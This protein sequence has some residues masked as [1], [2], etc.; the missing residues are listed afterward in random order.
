MNVEAEPRTLRK[1]PLFSV[2]GL[3]VFAILDG[4]RRPDLLDRL[5]AQDE[6]WACLFSGPLA[7]EVA[8]RS[9]YLVRLRPE[10]ELTAWVLDGWGQSGGIFAAI[11]D[12]LPFKKVRNHFRGFLQVKGPDDQVLF[13]RYYDPRVSSKYLPTMNAAEI[14]IVFGPVRHYALESDTGEAMLR[15]RVRDGVVDEERISLT[16]DRDFRFRL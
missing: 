7:P 14:E 4:A 8:A 3:A 13:F 9:P 15:F 6:E 2:E 5:K 10:A 16:P 1:P 11:D 12:E